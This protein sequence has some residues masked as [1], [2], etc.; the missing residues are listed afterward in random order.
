MAY[1]DGIKKGDK[2]FNFCLRK[3]VTVIDIRCNEEYPIIINGG[4]DITIEG[5]YCTEEVI[6]LFLWQE[7]DILDINNLPKKPKKIIDTFEKLAL[8]LKENNLSLSYS[9]IKGNPMF[10]NNI[11]DF[12]KTLDV[13]EEKYNVDIILMHNKIL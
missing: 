2:L 5:T 8:F 4:V 10:D 6:P 9:I 11:F 12:K 13:I 7:V 3:W 1:L